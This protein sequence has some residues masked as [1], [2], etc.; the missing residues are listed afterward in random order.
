MKKF[1]FPAFLA[2]ALLAGRNSFAHCEIPCGI[3]N[4]ELR[5]ALLYEHF[6]T[7]EKA[8]NQMTEL[9]KEGDINYNQLIRWTG[10][11]EDH[12]NE[13]QHV[14]TQY[15]ITQRVKLPESTEGEAY[16]KYVKQLSLLHEIIVYAMKSKQTTDTGNV[17]K[18]RAALK[19]FED[20]YFEGK[21]RHKIEEAH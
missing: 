2:L 3:Y 20:L 11:K 9:S 15:F 7:I 16:D 4:D 18:M 19:K 10:A 1:I 17:E 13:I 6:T 14:V 8:M 5:V 21:H 12:A